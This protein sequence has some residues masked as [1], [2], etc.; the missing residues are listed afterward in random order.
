MFQSKIG[1][2]GFRTSELELTLVFG[3]TYELSQATAVAFWIR[4][5]ELWDLRLKVVQ[6]TL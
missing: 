4:I 1:G 5:S 3:P 2:L 6:L